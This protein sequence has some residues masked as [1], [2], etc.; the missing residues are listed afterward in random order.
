M[1]DSNT[2]IDILAYTR[3]RYENPRMVEN[4]ELGSM[5]G[6]DIFGSEKS[7]AL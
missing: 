1:R 7:Y 3:E 6:Q 2:F 5:K 4:M